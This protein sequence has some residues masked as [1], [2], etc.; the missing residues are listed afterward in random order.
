MRNLVAMPTLFLL[1]TGC[2]SGWKEALLTNNRSPACA[3]ETRCETQ[4]G[5][6]QR[7]ETSRCESQ[8]SPEIEVK[9]PRQKIVVEMPPPPTCKAP[10]PPA[11][12]CQ[13]PCQPPCPPPC[14]PAPAPQS[15]AIGRMFGIGMMTMPIGPVTVP[16]TAPTLGLPTLGVGPQ[17]AAAGN[18]TMS[19]QGSMT[20]QQIAMLLAASGNLTPQQLSIVLQLAGQ[21][22]PAQ[23]SALLSIQA[24]NSGTTAAP[25]ATAGA[26]LGAPVS[27]GSPIQPAVA[28]NPTTATPAA[29]APSVSVLQ[30]QLRQMEQRLREL[31]AIRAGGQQ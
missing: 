24:A 3:A 10:V 27:T 12:P 5:E 26:G 22:T 18:A 30:E 9:A 2:N 17:G 1:L 14:Q 13:P 16:A 6:T 19:L 28:A 4:R 7:C 20:A 31:E 8:E 11:A 29:G 23:I 15:N 25:V 21:L